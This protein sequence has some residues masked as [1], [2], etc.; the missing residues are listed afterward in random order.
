MRTQIPSAALFETHRKNLATLLDEKAIAI[1]HSN[2]LYPTNADALLPYKQSNDLFYLTGITQEET[3][4]LLFPD[5]YNEKD[6]EIL[7]LREPSAHLAIWEGHKL[8]KEQ[9]IKRTGI[10]RIEWVASFDNL[11]DRLAPQAD[12]F[13]LSTNEYATQPS[14]VETRNH[15]FVTECK[16]RYPLHCY[17]RLAPLMSKL[18]AIK[19]DEEVS[20]TKKACEITEAGFRRIPT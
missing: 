20:F 3:V 5:A 15:R 6:R 1:V 19:S 11:L 18:R 8:T 4:L 14:S 16:R 2:D 12:A 17:G 10:K 13:F 7:F 9:A